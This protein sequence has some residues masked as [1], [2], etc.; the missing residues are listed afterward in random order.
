MTKAFVLAAGKGKRFL[1]FSKE[2]PKPLF[3]IGEVSLIQNNLNN[4]KKCGID[5]VVI[6]IFHLGEKIINALGDGSEYGLKISYS[7]ESELLGTGGGIANAIHLFDEPFIVLSG[8]VWTDFNFSHLRLAKNKLAHMVLIKNPISNNEGDVCLKDGLVKPAEEDLTYTYS[9][10]SILS[11]E[12]FNDDNPDRFG[13]WEEILLPAS[14]KNFVS[15]ELYNGLLNNLN[16]LE[17][18]EKLDA[19]L[20]GE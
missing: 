20:T 4:L 2:L 8:D 1:P 5:E 18:A 14:I 15:G 7:I 17:E 13:L 16:T 19:L 12:L 3:K 6:N 11:P 10:I 9:G